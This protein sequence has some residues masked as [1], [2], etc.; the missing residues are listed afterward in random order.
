[1]ETAQ[2]L[3]LIS[4]NTSDI[5]A[6][7]SMDWKYMHVSGSTKFI[8][9]YAPEELV[10]HS[11]YENMHPEDLNAILDSTRQLNNSFKKQ[12]LVYRLKR[13]DGNYVWIE[14]ILRRVESNPPMVLAVSH[15]ITTRRYSE[16][17]VKKF[18]EGVQ[19]ASDCIVMANRD[20]KIIYVNP[21]AKEVTGFPPEEMIGQ[22]ANMVWGGTNDANK[23]V[24]MWNRLQIEKIPYIGEISNVNKMGKTYFTDVRVSPIF[25]QN[26]EVTFYIGISRDITKAKEVD[27]MKNE[28]IS[29]ASHQLQTPLTNIKWRLEM[30]MGPGFSDLKP[31]QQE[32]INDINKANIRMIELINS[33][34]N[35]SRIESGRLV[36]D[37]KTVSLEDLMLSAIEDFEN[38]LKDKNI[39]IKMSFQT[40]IYDVSVDPKLMRNVYIN[41]LSNAIKYTPQNG[42]IEVAIYTE[43]QKIITRVKDDGCGIPQDEQ[44]YVFQKFYRAKN[45]QQIETEG[46]GLGLYMIKAIMDASNGTVWFE[47]EENKGTTF[48]VA[49]GTKGMEAKPGE[50]TIS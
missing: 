38:K 13:K 16:E 36:I 22:H 6:L 20:G 2:F 14:T 30:L 41:L 24:E 19:Y 8:L 47:S 34:L 27:R 28:F 44:K 33:L 39:K 3:Q 48:Y 43:D 18:V 5:V 50:V 25:D 42:N 9:G 1:M 21:S 37:P 23:I 12:Y 40:N 29:L 49:M 46:T 32:Y 15:D 17:M 31:K 7:Y 10:G 26:K 45:A 35:I 11:V 4:D